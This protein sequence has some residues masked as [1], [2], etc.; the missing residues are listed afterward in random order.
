MLSLRV[1]AVIGLV[2]LA[3]CF[4]FDPKD[5]EGAVIR[6]GDDDDC[7][8]GFT[9]QVRTGFCTANGGENDPPLLV[10]GT[11][12]FAPAIGAPGLDVT[13]TVTLNEALLQ[14][15][16]LV[17]AQRRAQTSP[18]SPATG[19]FAAGDTTFTFVL[20]IADDE[21]RSAIQLVVEATDLQSNTSSLVIPESL[22]VDVDGP[23]LG[24]NNIVVAFVDDAGE[25]VAK[26]FSAASDTIR[27]SVTFPEDDPTTLVSAILLPIN[28]NENNVDSDAI[29]TFTLRENAFANLDYTVPANIDALQVRVVAVDEFGNQTIVRSGAINVDR[30]APILAANA[31]NI[32]GNALPGAARLR[33]LTHALTLPGAGGDV[34]SFCVQGD[35]DDGNDHCDDDDNFIAKA[36]I[37]T[38]TVL[39]RP[40][41]LNVEVVVRD[42]AFNRGS[43]DVPLVLTP[44]DVV[45]A[46]AVLQPPVGQSAVRSNDTV[47][48]TGS[49]LPGVAL[50]LQ[51]QANGADRGNPVTVGGTDRNVDGTYSATINLADIQG[52]TDGDQLSVEFNASAANIPLGLDAVGVSDPDDNLAVD[53]TPPVITF[54]IDVLVIP[55]CANP[56][57][58]PC[59]DDFTFE[60]SAT[61]ANTIAAIEVRD[62]VDDGVDAIVSQ[63]FINTPVD[64]FAGS[65]T[66]SFVDGVGERVLRVLAR[67]GAGNTRTEEITI[68]LNDEVPTVDIQLD[69]A[70]VGRELVL[71]VRPGSILRLSGTTSADVRT[72]IN[73]IDASLHFV[74]DLG[75]DLCP[76]Q[77]LAVTLS[78]IV[79]DATRKAVSLTAQTF[80]GSCAGASEV[81]AVLLVTGTS[82]FQSNA[83]A[84]R[85]RSGGGAVDALYYDDTAPVIS[86]AAIDVSTFQRAR[87]RDISGTP[88]AVVPAS[89]VNLILDA[90]DENP[91]V[92]TIG[93]DVAA[94]TSGPLP[95]TLAIDLGNVDSLRTIEVDAVDEVGNAAARVTVQVVLDRV[96]PLPAVTAQLAYVEVADDDNPTGDDDLS[97]FTIQGFAGAVVEPNLR[98]LFF[99]NATEI[100]GPLEV[101]A[102]ANANGSF[103]AV[104]VTGLS[105]P[106]QHVVAI[107]VDDAGNTSTLVEFSR[108]RFDI[109]SFDGAL[110]PRDRT[111][112][113]ALVPSDDP[114]VNVAFPTLQ[115]SPT[116]DVFNLPLDPPSGVVDDSFASIAANGAGF[117]ASFAPEADDGLT[118]GSGTIV[119]RFTG[120]G[121]GLHP[122]SLSVDGVIG[123]ADFTAPTVNR[124]RLAIVEGP[125]D[126]TLS[127]SAGTVSDLAG[128][129]ANS[130]ADLRISINGV[131]SAAVLEDGSFTAS[132]GANAPD[133]I[134]VAVVADD[135]DN[136][137]IPVTLTAPVITEVDVTETD[138]KDGD[139]ITI[140]FLVT[141]EEA[142][143]ADPVVTVGGV[144]ATRTTT[145]AEGVDGLRFTYTFAVNDA[146]VSEGQQTVV[147]TT[148]DATGHAASNTTNNA[149][150]FDF[151]APTLVLV[152]PNQPTTNNR[153]LRTTIADARP[154]TTRFTV[155]D[156]GSGLFFD[157]TDFVSVVPVILDDENTNATQ[158]SLQVN[159]LADGVAYLL[160]STSTDAAG[161]VGTASTNFTFDTTAPTLSFAIS[162][163]DGD[164]VEVTYA[165]SGNETLAT[166]ECRIDVGS[167]FA[168]DQ[169]GLV[170]VPFGADRILQ[171]RGRDTAGN[172]SSTLTA[173]PITLTPRLRRVVS[174]GETMCAIR[175]IDSGLICWGDNRDAHLGDADFVDD[176]INPITV[177]PTSGPAPAF[178]G[179]SQIWTGFGPEPIRYLDV[180]VGSGALCVLTEVGELQCVGDARTGLVAGL[181][182]ETFMPPDGYQH[183][184]ANTLGAP[185]NF[186]R[187]VLNDRTGCALALDRV[188]CW[189]EPVARGAVDGEPV[190]DILFFGSPVD[191][192]LGDKHLCGLS[193]SR[194]EVE[195]VGVNTRGQLGPLVPLGARSDDPVPVLTANISDR[196]EEMMVGPNS[197]C[198]RRVGQ[199]ELECVGDN[200]GGAFSNEVLASVGAFEPDD[201]AD[202]PVVL[203]GLPALVASSSTD[204]RT[205]GVTGD[206]G[207]IR[208]QGTSSYGARGD[209]SFDVVARGVDVFGV[210]TFD[211]V[212]AFPRTTCGL[213]SSDGALLCAG[214]TG[215]GEIVTSAPSSAGRDLSGNAIDI[216]VGPRTTCVQDGAGRQCSGDARNN[217]WLANL[218][219]ASNFSMSGSFTSVIGPGIAAPREL[220]LGN[221][222]AC[223]VDGSEVF[224]SGAQGSFLG[225]GDNDGGQDPSRLPRVEGVVDSTN[226]RIRAFEVFVGG[227]TACALGN[228]SPTQGLVCWGEH[229]PQGSQNVA[230]VVDQ[231]LAPDTPVV[232]G[233]RHT[234]FVAEDQTVRCFGDPARGR[235]GGDV[236]GSVVTVQDELTDD[237]LE[238][239]STNRN[240]LSASGGTTCAVAS[241]AGGPSAVYCWGDNRRGQVAFNDN[242]PFFT[243]AHRLDSPDIPS[244]TAIFVGNGVSCVDSGDLRCWGRRIQDSPLPPPPPDTVERLFLL[245]GTPTE[246]TMGDGFLCGNRNGGV[247]C[248]GANTSGAFGDGLGVIST[249]TEVA[250]PEVL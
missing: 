80:V 69:N 7:P 55:P 248:V 200:D 119:A 246:V 243:K 144:N 62:D 100:D 165:V 168:C 122:N 202:Q 90:D 209:G 61:D 21:D 34:Q 111:L 103:D 25:D 9:C 10:V 128:S 198:V 41:I 42:K 231:N 240:L 8:G 179:P 35:T 220:A 26:N 245:E 208:C 210:D 212:Y 56:A 31:V 205:C 178:I 72:G 152:N 164:S 134:T 105:A 163:A 242:R 206:D 218:Q 58:Q 86:T 130:V 193:S 182:F 207:R 196:F 70:D 79:D 107:V 92:A 215:H 238:I 166:F 175:T 76:P 232:M 40:G 155:Q 68:E 28:T 184:L 136:P 148:T 117:E 53:D 224:C 172:L 141:D 43:L 216:V 47:T 73:D 190:E 195:C 98:V 126:D 225:R 250:F 146:Q 133:T 185:P 214:D 36:N 45:I 99:A 91:V 75:A 2:A 125:G 149:V 49:A 158:T 18:L 101:P 171:F 187:V 94:A 29:G 59:D 93:R 84:S 51:L 112:A 159:A 151:T 6:C 131:D 32:D 139:T 63:L 52:L 4:A 137:G 189:G 19:D 89:A 27:L 217:L 24:A 106:V 3:G 233:E 30:D 110:G 173:A 121:P 183:V 109:A 239:F 203:T 15:P 154:T 14:A 156:L 116:V 160:V 57:A 157:G 221:R 153:D 135:A 115:G 234:C 114:E 11:P 123:S 88:T 108:P 219:D 50:A 223:A 181:S 46:D 143:A 226:Q 169:A 229:T 204:G 102:N 113:I 162:P 211:A 201:I 96:A 127:G 191:I 230:V 82:G 249:A 170:R 247:M 16:L 138:A 124:A 188:S 180:A 38:I 228:G 97:E 236:L 87:P 60:V 161:N 120:R 23:N 237:P 227:D 37:F 17:D 77:T 20:P 177:D 192:G 132:L 222:F 145:V 147:V 176:G 167:F 64:T 67:D 78:D 95:D 150:F 39:D 104:D 44:N 54:N 81:F 5:I 142:P 83:A 85:S 235:L 13:V 48:V 74:D 199:S 71:G 241:V 244:A 33:T 194:T 22:P 197:V 186:S 213:R 12:F 65:A 174:D 1:F 140:T 118:E 66:I 129:T